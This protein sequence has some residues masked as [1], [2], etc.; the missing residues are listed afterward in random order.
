MTAR[1][2]IESKNSYD[3]PMTRE[4]YDSLDQWDT[5]CIGIGR[6]FRLASIWRLYPEDVLN[7]YLDKVEDG[8][9][10]MNGL[11]TQVTGPTTPWGN[12]VMDV[13]YSPASRKTRFKAM[14][15]EEYVIR[16][17]AD[18]EFEDDET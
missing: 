9:T 7:D 14:V 15:A 5:Y 8:W 6:T 11:F 4:S 3:S 12:I 17:K 2:Y 1:L 10:G 16:T 18:W 13:T